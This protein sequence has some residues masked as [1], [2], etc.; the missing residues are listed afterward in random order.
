MRYIKVLSMFVI[1][2]VA[3]L[4]IST[5][6]T[7]AGAAALIFDCDGVQ[8]ISKSTDSSGVGACDKDTDCAVGELCADCIALT[9]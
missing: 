7:Y 5:I 1:L 8:V 6:K 4:L 2:A 3:L 9:V